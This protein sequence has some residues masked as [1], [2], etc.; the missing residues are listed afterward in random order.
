M[1]VANS[2][3]T[4]TQGDLVFVGLYLDEPKEFSVLLLRDLV[5]GTVVKFTDCG[6]SDASGFYNELGDNNGAW[7][8]TVGSGGLAAGTV[9]FFQPMEGQVSHG[10]VSGTPPSLNSLGD[11]LFAFQGAFGSPTLISGIH[12][13]YTILFG[14]T[15]DADWDRGVNSESTSQLPNVLTN[16]VNA[17]RVYNFPNYEERDNG[18][19]NCQTATDGSPAVLRSVTQLVLNWYVTNSAPPQLPEIPGSQS[20]FPCGFTVYTDAI[21]DGSTN[22]GLWGTAANWDINSQPDISLRTTIKMDDLVTIPAPTTARSLQT[23]ISGDG[24]LRIASGATLQQGAGECMSLDN[25]NAKLMGAGTLNGDLCHSAGN[26]EPEPDADGLR[27]EGSY[28]N[29]GGTVVLDVF[30]DGSGVNDQFVISGM[31]AL[32]GSLVVNWLTTPVAVGSYP[33]MK[34]GSR[35]GLFSS[36]TI[37]PVPGFSMSLS[38]TSTEA[39]INVS[40]SLP[41]ELVDFRAEPQA[42]AVLLEWRTASEKDNHGFELERSP[43]GKEWEQLAFVEGAGTTTYEQRY[44]F[45]DENPVAGTNYYRLK[46]VDFNGATDFSKIIIIDIPD[47]KERFKLVPNPAAGVVFLHPNFGFEDTAQVSLYDFMGKAIWLQSVDFSSYGQAAVPFDLA[48]VPAG[49][50]LLEIK[51]GDKKWV[52]KLVVE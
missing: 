49:I 42:G 48:L 8:W 30:G 31:A 46:Q 23:T 41:V 3:T 40:L 11:Q 9:V 5:A 20:P 16:G 10:T 14:G 28:T 45:L 17:I 44:D 43:N 13:N 21:W 24:K 18:V 37:P 38:Y 29:T 47:E 12:A 35:T 1:Q 50:Y 27:V 33:V 26:L 39:K 7:N 34:F 36:V 19:F 22:D 15:N 32:G 6:W 51:N 25:P 52:E 4:L 2:Q